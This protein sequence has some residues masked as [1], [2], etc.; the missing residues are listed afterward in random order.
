MSASL[1]RSS[2]I[3]GLG[4]SRK[5]TTQMFRAAALAPTESG[6]STRTREASLT[7]L[8]SQFARPFTVMA[9]ACVCGLLHHSHSVHRARTERLCFDSKIISHPT[10][11]NWVQGEPRGCASTCGV[12]E[13][14]SGTPGTVTCD[15]SSC[16]PDTKPAVKQCPQ[17]A[18]C[19]KA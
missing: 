16:D 17:T 6:T 1:P 8:A 13:G 14:K 10:I 3:P 11:G 7:A 12:G 2:S 4:Q 15:S 9:H 18:D 5:R 19:G